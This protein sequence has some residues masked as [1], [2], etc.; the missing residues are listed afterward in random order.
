MTISMG[1]IVVAVLLFVGL[2][3]GFSFSPAKPTGG[4][5]A[6]ADV[7]GGFDTAA[8]TAGFAVVVPQGVPAS[9]HGSSFSVTDAPGTPQ[10]PPTVRGGWLTPSGAFIT[11]IQSSGDP[12]AVLATELG[13]TSGSRLGT[14][15]TGGADWT[16]NPGVRQ[17]TAWW[18]VRNG[19]ML[20][21]TGSASPADFAALAGAV[22]P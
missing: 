6:T 14:V 7:R 11:L 16:V 5:A 18:R 13:Q 22:R 8:R 20:V 19:V 17:E 2:Y 12:A 15:R 3:G 10:A 9:W 4:V 21:I 1:V